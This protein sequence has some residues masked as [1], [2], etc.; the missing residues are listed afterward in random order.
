MNDASGVAPAPTTSKRE[1][2]LRNSTMKKVF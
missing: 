2:H 1:T